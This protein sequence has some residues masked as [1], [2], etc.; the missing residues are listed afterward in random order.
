M[1]VC[2]LIENLE[3]EL[4]QQLES[5]TRAHNLRLEVDELKDL[6]A[7]GRREVN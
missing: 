5:S 2:R 6:S 4:E 7:S 3:G 1:S